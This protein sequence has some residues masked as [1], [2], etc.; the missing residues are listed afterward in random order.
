A[1]SNEDELQGHVRNSLAHF[2]VPKWVSF[3]EDL[4][5]TA[6]GKVQKY[7]LRGRKAG[8]SQQ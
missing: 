7:V 2:K 4:P 3:V 8:I 5:K 6:T 1:E